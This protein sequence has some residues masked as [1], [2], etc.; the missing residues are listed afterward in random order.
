MKIPKDFI[1]HVM[2]LTVPLP[3]DGDTSN[4]TNEQ[5]NMLLIQ[6]VAVATMWC[7]HDCLRSELLK[8]GIDIGEIT[9]D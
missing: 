3:Y 6:S 9:F 4:L 7:Y 1:N 2:N 5:K 8:R